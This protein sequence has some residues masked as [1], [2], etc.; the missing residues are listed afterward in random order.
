MKSKFTFLGIDT[1]NYTT[2]V[3]LVSDDGEILGDFR[4][5]LT[6]KQGERGLR[7]SEA[8]FQHMINFPQIFEEMLSFLKVDYLDLKTALNLKAI[9]VST[10]PRP[11]ENSYMPC[12]RAGESFARTLAGGLGLPLMNFSHQEGHIEAA[13]NDQE[14][15]PKDFLCWHLS[16]G[17]CEL[18]KV[19]DNSRYAEK[20]KITVQDK[21]SIC[22]PIYEISKIGGSLD[23]SLGQMIDRIGV[24]LGFPFPAGRYIDEIA[25]ATGKKNEVEIM[26]FSKIKYQNLYFNISG[27]ETQ[28][29]RFIEDSAVTYTEKEDV[30]KQIAKQILDII[31]ELLM[32]VSIEAMDREN[33]HQIVFSGGVSASQYIRQKFS[34]NKFMKNYEVIFS[35]PNLSSDNAVG[36]ALLGRNVLL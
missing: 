25:L 12:F 5:L 27:I 6:V 35:D 22:E 4:K 26:K 20:N 32:K 18:L 19:R 16:G 21:L 33:I 3:S 11:V 28:I 31:S 34:D 23:I 13:L 29:G 1:S 15:A 9:C 30:S 36:I 7:Q 17:T 24:K 2:S 8:V 14:K 10:K